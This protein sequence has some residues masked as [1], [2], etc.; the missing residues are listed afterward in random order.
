LHHQ[1]PWVSAFRLRP[2]YSTNIPGSSAQIAD[3]G[4][5]ASVVMKPVHKSLQINVGIAISS[6][7]LFSGEPNPQRI[8]FQEPQ[9]MPESSGSAK[10]CIVVRFSLYVLQHCDMVPELMFYALVAPMYGSCHL[11]PLLL[12]K[13]RVL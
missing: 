2:N 13:T 11:G 3:H 9:W 7:G 5:S 4:M 6:I 8:V 12:S 1:L 10:P